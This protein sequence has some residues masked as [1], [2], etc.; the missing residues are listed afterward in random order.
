MTD[1]KAMPVG[2]SDEELAKFIRNASVKQFAFAGRALAIALELQSLR[3]RLSTIEAMP[4]GV[5]VKPL[6]WVKSNLVE[7]WTAQYPFGQFEI[8]HAI[9]ATH[10]GPSYT[11]Q[12]GICS[13]RFETLE[14]AQSACQADFTSRILSTIE[15][16]PGASWDE[17]YAT[18]QCCS[19]GP[20]GLNGAS[21]CEFCGKPEASTIDGITAA[22]WALA[23]KTFCGPSD[24]EDIGALAEAFAKDR[25]AGVDSKPVP[26]ALSPIGGEAE[27]VAWLHPTAG[28]AHERREQVAIHCH[29]DG[30]D[31]VP[32]YFAAPQGGVK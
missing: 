23:V 4:V 25:A 32:L 24:N 27:P 7:R 6:E 21:Q 2:V 8:T 3:A 17:C 10:E 1:T 28:W 16:G 20:H 11:W 9:Y 22:D 15:A 14:E 31:P 26:A 12:R 13:E 18:G 5:R 29:K 19:Y 30:P